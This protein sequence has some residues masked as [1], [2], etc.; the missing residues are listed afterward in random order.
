MQMQSN[1]IFH[2]VISPP[3][4]KNFDKEIIFLHSFAAEEICSPATVA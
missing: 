4:A 1:A 3:L 2:S